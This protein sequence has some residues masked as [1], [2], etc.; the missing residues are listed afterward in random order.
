MS[1]ISLESMMLDVAFLQL[2]FV[3]LQIFQLILNFLRALIV[4]EL[5]FYQRLL[6]IVLNDLYSFFIL[7]SVVVLSTLLNVKYVLFGIY[8]ISYVMLPFNVWLNLICLYWKGLYSVLMKD[9]DP[10]FSLPVI[11]LCI[12]TAGLRNY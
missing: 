6:C 5:G 9:I 10:S 8:L 2:T 11:C 3:R 4:N 1:N 12:S 7:N